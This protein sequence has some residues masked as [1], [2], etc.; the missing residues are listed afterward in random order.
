MRDLAKR[1][2]E[3]LVVGLIGPLVIFAVLKGANTS[4]FETETLTMF[5]LYLAGE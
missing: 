2:L 3:I 4:F 5:P 1:V